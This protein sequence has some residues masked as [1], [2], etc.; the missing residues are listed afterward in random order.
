MFSKGIATFITFAGL[1]TTALAG[2]I[3]RVSNSGAAD[4][5]DDKYIVVLK[6][7][8]TET[9]VREHES[10]ISRF[11]RNSARDL[12]GAPTHGLRSK[13]GF[14]SGFKGYSGGFDSA[15][16]QEILKSPEVAFVEQDA[17]VRLSAEQT[18]STWGLDRISHKTFATPY[19]YVYDENTSGAGS[20]VFVIDTGINVN[21]DEF[22][23]ANGTRARWGANFAGDGSSSDGNGHGTHCAGTVAGKTYGVAKKANV[24]AVKVL[25]AQGSG[26][27]SG[28]ISGMNWVAQN[29]KANKDVASMSLGGGKSAAVNS[30]VDAIYAAGITVVVAA[31]NENRDASLVSP[32][33]APKAITVAA[34]DKT[35][36]RA[37]FSNFGTLIDIW[38]PGVDVLSAWIGSNTATRTISGTSM[39][40]PHV[41][42]LAAYLISAS[43]SGLSPAAVDAKIKSLALSDVVKDPK[44]SPNKLAYNGNA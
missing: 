41:A 24:V 5:I 13:F 25:N 38:A 33:S 9:Q 18:D 17:I 20:T 16:L 39:A 28:V 34:M 6:S 21:H 14:K 12:S 7:E 40:C 31:G 22:K 44:G 3:L 37:Y 43:S 23:T 19:T 2:P 35:N 1:A 11:H 15:T 42:G 32:A 27:N 29:G 4:L 8:L 30:A 10:R 36:T 26:T